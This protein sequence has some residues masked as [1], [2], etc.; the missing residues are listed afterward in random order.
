MQD[1]FFNLC[2]SDLKVTEAAV[3]KTAII[4]SDID[5]YN[6][7]IV[8][9][10]TGILCSTKEE[11]KEAIE[12]MTKDKARTMGLNLHESLKNDPNHNLDLIN[13]IRLKYLL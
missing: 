9:G 10:E 2:K 11:W 3:T 13:N 6:G 5:I 8:N 1:N 4:A 7:S 12:S